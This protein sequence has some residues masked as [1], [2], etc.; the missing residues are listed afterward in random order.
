M[1]RRVLI[2]EAQLKQYRATLI[3]DLA[4]RLRR[5]DIDLKVAYS[6]P[7]HRERS[8]A[9]SLELPGDLGLKLPGWWLLGDRVFVQ[10]AWRQIRNADLV[11]M[12]QGNK[13]VFNYV[14][15]AMSAL[16]RKRVGYW[17]HGYNHQARAPGASEWMK[18][19]LLTRVD[20]WFAYT[21]GV[22]RYLTAQG[23]ASRNITVL[24]NTIDT[25]ELVD[26]LDRVDEGA[27]RGR[28]GLAATAR[29]GLF[30]GSLY[31]EKMLDF[32]IEAAA[33]IRE[34]QPKFELVV[35]GD[36]PERETLRAAA[37][38]HP[39]V[40]YVGPAFGAERA[41]FF[42]ISDVFLMPGLV[43]LAI[44]DSFAAGLPVFTTNV[45]IHSPEIEYLVPGD[46]G[47]MTV[48]EPAAYATEVCRVLDDAGERGR[49]S[50]AA[51]ATAAR[52]T[53]AHMV[54]AFAT[55]ITRCLEDGK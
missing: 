26:A 32:L 20:W 51:R 35:V 39:F 54:E 31:R 45:P 43:G 44:V 10:S 9:D 21:E 25:R 49:M 27:V 30:C 16:R 5:D 22:A 53:M 12:E 48:H 36:G 24:Q 41:D 3:R 37:A 18:K 2:L 34:R 52:L 14:L 38:R 50:R 23:V 8:K 46:N 40:H 19:K 6:E 42:A 55:G 15:L 47:A 17:G 1:T 13:H 11:I 4:A 7:N 33:K 28:L 29:V